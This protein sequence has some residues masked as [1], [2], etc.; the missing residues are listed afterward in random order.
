MIL[1]PAGEMLTT[2]NE[3]GAV[4]W[5]RL[6]EPAAKPDLAAALAERFPDVATPE[7]EQDATA[8]L[9]ELLDAGLVVATDADG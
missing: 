7:L 1:D 3:A 8:F 5:D 9:E 4:V 2:L 6:R